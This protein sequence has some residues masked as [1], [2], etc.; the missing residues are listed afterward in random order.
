LPLEFSF[1]YHRS[2]HDFLLL[3]LPRSH[4]L[5]SVRLFHS[6]FTCSAFHVTL[7]GA[8]LFVSPCTIHYHHRIPTILPIT[9]LP[10]CRCRYTVPFPRSP[11]TVCLWCRL[12][13]LILMLVTAR[14]YR[15]VHHLL[16]VAVGVAHCTFYL[17]ALPFLVLI[18]STFLPCLRS[19]VLLP[20]L[21][22]TQFLHDFV[23]LSACWISVVHRSTFAFWP[24][25]VTHF[26]VRVR[27]LITTVL[28]HHTATRVNAWFLIQ[29]TLHR[30]IGEYDIPLTISTLFLPFYHSLHRPFFFVL[31]EHTLDLHCS[32]LCWGHWVPRAVQSI[33]PHTWYHRL[34]HSLPDTGGRP[35]CVECDSLCVVLLPPGT[36]PPAFA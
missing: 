24:R 26:P 16:G 12:N 18:R 11:A 22:H 27:R 8:A 7:F 10:V 35:H 30:F 25:S 17:R 2:F 33:M 6:P 19:A 14:L 5:R 29:I 36:V 1:T 31:Q 13:R 32:L 21:C 20:P 9:T 28:Y 15:Y 4:R 23:R 3:P 34:L